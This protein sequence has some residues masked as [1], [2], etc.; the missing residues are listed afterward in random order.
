MPRRLY[1]KKGIQMRILVVEDDTALREHLQQRLTESGFGVD[2]AANGVDGLF[3]GL[4]YPLDA[5]IVDLGLPK[6]PG[7]DVI[8][9]LR[10]HQRTFPIVILTARD[11]WQDKVEGLDAGA[12]DYVSKPFSFQAPA[13]RAAPGKGLDHVR[14]GVRPVCTRHLRT[15]AQGVRRAS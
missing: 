5:A 3:A 6:L 4:N 13:G 8:K 9:R 7:L 12:D 1:W 10:A 15:D 2:V 14:T 11:S